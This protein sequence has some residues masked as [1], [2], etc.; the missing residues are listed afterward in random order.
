MS[1]LFDLTYHLRL[2]GVIVL[3]VR[4]ENW[5]PID[6]PSTDGVYCNTRV[7]RYTTSGLNILGTRHTWRSRI[8]FVEKPESHGVNGTFFLRFEMVLRHSKPFINTAVTVTHTTIS[9]SGPL[10]VIT[11]HFGV[12]LKMSFKTVTV[13]VSNSNKRV[14]LLGCH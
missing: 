3:Q 13:A 14:D 5:V 11:I 4:N 10:S 9:P 1:C 8:S 2:P 12:H 6:H 7:D